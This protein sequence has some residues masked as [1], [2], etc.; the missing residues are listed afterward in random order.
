MAGMEQIKII[1]EAGYYI[2]EVV[3]IDPFEKDH[4]IVLA[5]SA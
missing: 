1:E 5:S 3:E 2:H 4:A